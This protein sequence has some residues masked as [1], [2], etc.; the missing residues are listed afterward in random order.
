MLEQL[1]AVSRER[2]TLDAFLDHY[3]YLAASA[4]ELAHSS[5]RE[6]RRALEAIV[7]RY[8]GLSDQD[9]PAQRQAAARARFQSARARVLASA[10]AL[11]RLRLRLALRLAGRMLPTREVGKA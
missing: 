2:L 7:E 10:G 1:W 11:D 3:G 5:W 9:H 4:G 8:R 6:D